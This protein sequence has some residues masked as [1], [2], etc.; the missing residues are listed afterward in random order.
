[1]FIN[2]IDIVNFKNYERLSLGF[3]EGVNLFVGVNGSGKTALLEAINVALG[4]FFEEQEHKMRRLINRS[5][6]RV[7]IINQMPIRAAQASIT[8]FSSIIGGEWTREHGEKQNKPKQEHVAGTYGAHIFDSFYRDGDHSLAPLIA[9]YSTQR[10]FKDAAQSAKQ[11]FDPLQGRKNGYLQCLTENAIKGT[12]VDWLKTAEIS[13]TSKYRK[14]IE[15]T[16]LVLQNVERAIQKTLVFFMRDVREEDIKI[17]AEASFDFELFVQIKKAKSLP[18]GYYSDGFRNIIYLVMDLIW[19][20]SQ[21]NPWLDLEEIAAQVVGAVT[22]DEIDLHLHPR[23]QSKAIRILQML[24]PKVQFFITTHSPSVVANF[25]GGS[26]FVIN[27]GEVVKYGQ[28][29]FG[30]EIGAV[31][32]NVLGASDRHGPTQDKIDELLRLVDDVT[33]ETPL[34]QQKLEALIAVLGEEDPEVQRI[35]ALMAYQKSE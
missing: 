32:R 25:E 23:W 2:R 8:A 10:L 13:Q 33:E 5:E 28:R 21:L 16:D 6:L 17:Y 19:R 27:E 18:I 7:S 31:L 29:F 11:K 9:Y 34:I 30:R 22:I 26:L 35:L 12:L 20:A 15:E 14:G 3:E 4:G 1:M 24:L